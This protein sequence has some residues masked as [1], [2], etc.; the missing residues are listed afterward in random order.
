MKKS[1]TQRHALRKQKMLKRCTP[2]RQDLGRPQLSA[3]GL[4]FD[5]G[6]RIQAIASGGIPL[7]HK[8]CEQLGLKESIDK[9]ARVFKQ[10]QP[11]YESDH[12][13]NIAFN[14]L[15]GGT[16]IEHIEHRRRDTAYLDALG[17]HSIP[18]PTTAGDF[19]RRFT[20]KQTIDEL[21]EAFNRVRLKAWAK[22]DV[23]FFKQAI[24]E[25]DGTICETYGE[26]KE[27]MD[28]SYD[29]RWGYHPLVVSLAN[30][31]EPLY[32]LNRSGNRP[33]H[34]GAA[35]YFDKAGR[36]CREAGFQSIHFRGDTDFSQTTYLDGWDREGVTF[37]FGMD[38]RKN[39]VNRAER[40]PAAAWRGL[41]RPSRVSA[42]GRSR[43]KP[44]NI[45]EQVIDRRG[46]RHMK[47]IKEEVAE[48]PYRPIACNK[49]YRLIILKKT[50]S[51]T[52]GLFEDME[53]ETR[54]FFYL[55]NRQD[56]SPAGVV[57]D[58]RKRCDQENL[59]AHLK[60]G[61]HA[62]T[63][64]LNNLHANWAYAVM[65]ALAWSLK[66][67]AALLLPVTG[68]WRDKHEEQKQKLLRMEFHTFRQALM[69]IPA[70]IVRSGRILL[71]RLLNWNEWTPAYFR[72]ANLIHKPMR[73]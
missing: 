47:L 6:Q 31:A 27:G 54:Y 59:N 1:M 16:R 71:I 45:K 22:Q 63:M 3:A 20:E 14:I 18:D 44:D 9:S 24:I 29:G 72:L 26:C 68:R 61:V 41:E 70:Q 30:T 5:L 8:L 46:F 40:L 58:A 67:W 32:L 51:V 55:S 52:Q 56:L 73:C 37:T 60:N 57:D 11:Y 38:G 34:E 25:A 35:E 48:V 21:Q 65:A 39:L 43:A 36:L 66:A 50:I 33:S 62:L 2:K 49:D 69:N 28:I 4:S 10:H 42:S 7:I 19:C 23:E 64:P 53:L 13:L 15:S 12:V 17:A